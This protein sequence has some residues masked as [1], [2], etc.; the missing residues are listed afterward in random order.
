M[1]QSYLTPSRQERQVFYGVVH[2]RAFSLAA[3]RLGV[4]HT[5]E[6]GAADGVNDFILLIL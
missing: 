5:L 3:W 1:G 6:S 4:S 2:R